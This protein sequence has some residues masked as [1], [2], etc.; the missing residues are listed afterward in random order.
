MKTFQGLS[1]EN[2]FDRDFMKKIL[3]LGGGYAGVTTAAGLRGIN[4][5]VTLVN[6][7]SYHH[8]TTLLHQP[9]VGRR[10]YG[11]ISIYTTLAACRLWLR[12]SGHGGLT[13]CTC[14]GPRFDN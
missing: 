6:K 4:A 10:S 11:D 3:I 9:A 14:T 1:P 8:L 5:E 12:S 13:L 7:H 2:T